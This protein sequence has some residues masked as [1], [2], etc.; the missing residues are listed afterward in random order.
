MRNNQTQRE[1]IFADA[2]SLS[3]ALQPIFLS[4]AWAEDDV[5]SFTFESS[6]QEGQSFGSSHLPS[7]MGTG[8]L[9]T[10]ILHT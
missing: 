3:L 8:D 10:V 1:R 6:A 9:V 5:P 7:G 4:M 2:L